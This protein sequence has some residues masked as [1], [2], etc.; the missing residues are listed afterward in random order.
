MRELNETLI[1]AA[2][3]IAAKIAAQ[4][5]ADMTAPTVTLTR[6]E[7]VLAQGLLEGAAVAMEKET[8]K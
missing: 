6:E 1:T 7:A 3:E 2:R 4:L 8:G 5:D